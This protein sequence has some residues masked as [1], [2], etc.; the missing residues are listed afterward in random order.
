MTTLLVVALLV[1][2]FGVGRL[3]QGVRDAQGVLSP[4]GRRRRER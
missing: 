4:E 1:A 3:F 2:A